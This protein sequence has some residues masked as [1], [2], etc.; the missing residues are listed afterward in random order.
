MENRKARELYVGNLTVGIVSSA[1]LKELFTAPLL[2]LPG[3]NPDLDGV[4]PVVDARVDAGGKFAFVEFR[5]ENL[6]TTALSLFNNM[7]LCGRPM[8]VARPTGYVDP[9][10]QAPQFVVP[11]P[12]LPAGMGGM[13]G[14]A[15]AGMAGVPPAPPPPPEA[16]A[17]RVLRL[18]N[19]LGEAALT[20]DA[21]YAECVEDIKGECERFGAISSFAIPRPNELHGHSAEDVGKCFVRYEEVSSAAKAFAQLNGRDFDGNKVRATFMPE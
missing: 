11:P 15:M 4:P 9:G 19:L 20:D 13:A 7:E 21:E 10:Q 16:P 12:I 8:S 6:C 2:T 18:E 17:T 3:T 14:A 1:M 5:D